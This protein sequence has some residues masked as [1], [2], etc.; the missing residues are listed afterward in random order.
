M[1]TIKSERVMGQPFHSITTTARAFLRSQ[2]R[3]RVAA[4]YCA[5]H[6]NPLDPDAAAGY[7]RLALHCSKPTCRHTR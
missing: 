1:K 7:I 6:K 3:G 4:V 5:L 2:P